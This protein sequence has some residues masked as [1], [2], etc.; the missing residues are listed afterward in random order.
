[1]F[2]TDSESNWTDYEIL[3][4]HWQHHDLARRI[5][6]SLSIVSALT[7]ELEPER[8]L[9]RFRERAWD[10]FRDHLYDHM[11]SSDSSDDPFSFDLRDEGAPHDPLAIH[12]T[13]GLAA[14]ASLYDLERTTVRQA[15]T[16]FL[17]RFDRLTQVSDGGE[18]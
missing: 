2:A 3:F 9:Q 14:G 11:A 10:L 7:P 15:Y 4:R 6:E 8:Y 5:R 16:S 13:R 1:M 12:W 17:G 18:Q